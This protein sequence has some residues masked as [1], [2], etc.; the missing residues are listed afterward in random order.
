MLKKILSGG[1]PKLTVAQLGTTASVSQFARMLQ[2]A[3]GSHPLTD[4]TDAEVKR[5]ALP[6]LSLFSPSS[7]PLLSLFLFSSLPLSRAF[8][9]CAR[10]RKAVG[11]L[12]IAA[13]ASPL[14]MW[15]QQLTMQ[16]LG[17]SRAAPVSALIIAEANRAG[18]GRGK[19]TSSLANMNSVVKII[20]S[21]ILGR[22]YTL[23]GNKG[24]GLPYGFCVAV[25]MAANVALLA[26]K[27]ELAK[28]D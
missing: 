7:L 15:L 28:A 10:V 23:R 27:H 19:V 17:A 21:L 13:T 12:A 25:L 8:W 16:T 6:L 24:S 3:P 14:V 1:M 26:A 5:H 9:G 20:G 22:L 18:I 2:C 4:C 11:Y